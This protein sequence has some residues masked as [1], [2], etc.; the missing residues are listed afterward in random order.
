MKT[1][2]RCNWLGRYIEKI[3]PVSNI[4]REACL[5]LPS[6]FGP[7]FRCYSSPKLNYKEIEN[8]LPTSSTQNIFDSDALIIYPNPIDDILFFECD[9]IIKHAYISNIKG[10]VVLKDVKSGDNLDILDSGLY[11]L[12]IELESFK[13]S[14][15]FIKK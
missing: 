12:T 3:G 2:D 10:E 6:G 9:Q 15:R 1:R 11:F 7:N 14:K 5:G 4:F 13:T 8:C